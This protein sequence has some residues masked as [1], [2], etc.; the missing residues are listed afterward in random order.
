MT[1]SIAT[2]NALLACAVVC[3]GCSFEAPESEAA[4]TSNTCSF[5]EEC[6]AD[7]RCMASMC[8]ARSIDDTLR[9]VLDVA[10][11][12]QAEGS[13]PVS[14][15][16]PG[17]SV[18]DG[19][20]SRSRSWK[21]A[22]PASVRGKIRNDGAV[23]DAEVTLTAKSTMVG[24]PPKVVT[25]SIASAAVAQPPEHDFE[26][27]VATEGEYTLRVQPKDTSLPPY[28]E[29]YQVVQGTFI[30]VDYATLDYERT[31]QFVGDAEERPMVVRAFDV[32]TGELIS[33]TA[34]VVED[35]ATL[36]FAQEPDEFRLVVRPEGAYESDNVTG[37]GCDH[38]TPVLP[39]F[40]ALSSA[41]DEVD[42]ALLVDLPPAPTRVA[43][44]ASVVTCDA[45]GADGAEPTDLPVSLRSTRVALDDPSGVWTAEVATDTR[46]AID[47]DD[48]DRYKLCVDVFPGEYEVVVTPPETEPCEIFAERLEVSSQ[49]GKTAGGQ[50]LEMK[51][52]AQLRGT[53]S[54]ERT[55]LAATAVDVRSL[56]RPL[57]ELD[58][59]DAALTE[60][61]RS[62]QTTTD[63]MG[64][65]RLPVDRGSYDVTIKPPSG[66]GYAW[67]VRRDVTIGS[68]SAFTNDIE[69]SSPV[70]IE[71]SI[72][73]DRNAGAGDAVVGAEITAYAVVVDDE[74][75]E[76]AIAV[77]KA[78]ADESGSFMLL[79]PPAIHAG[80]VTSGV[81]P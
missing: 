74:N 6:N 33:S 72:E 9:I 54:S 53:L 59:G 73:Y 40:S 15:T 1:R 14:I 18:E 22:A 56:G 29:V 5:D 2:L 38:D 52:A 8:V 30:D 21:L 3:S 12:Q 10:P 68:N 78:T 25:A 23:V 62:R 48:P 60:F 46:A 41:L 81:T 11:L 16:L 49:D 70:A 69:M 34:S 7:S 28:Q 58:A 20:S 19:A 31:I 50:K 57:S 76:R 45:Q 67:Y 43:F 36:R 64:E 55:P 75:V 37:D 61:S 17:F 80:W 39:S 27:R 51:N 4:F 63:A 65:F 77:G 24:I 26:L 35:V 47:E 71:C 13:V 42:D 32:A 66:S 44:T 79:L